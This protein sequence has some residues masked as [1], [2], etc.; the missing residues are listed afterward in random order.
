MKKWLKLSLILIG[1]ITLVIMSYTLIDK[2]KSSETYKNKIIT[3]SEICGYTPGSS[4]NSVYQNCSCSGK[5]I[6]LDFS[7]GGKDK[8]YCYKG[9]CSECKCYTR[10][11]HKE[12]SCE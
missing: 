4:Y 12:T 8:F 5:L 3:N 11:T 9:I 2:I 1:V 6:R 7:D 10:L